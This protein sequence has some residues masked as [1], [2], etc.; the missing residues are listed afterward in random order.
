LAIIF[1]PI[2]R[3]VNAQR[4]IVMP[5]GKTRTSFTT[6]D[7]GEALAPPPSPSFSSP[8]LR[9][10]SLERTSGSLIFVS[11]CYREHCH[12]STS[13]RVSTLINT[14][15]NL[16]FF[17]SVWCRRGNRSLDVIEKK[18]RPSLAANFVRFYRPCGI[19]KPRR[20]IS[21]PSTW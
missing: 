4:C 15:S 2:C 11:P 6:H 20:T 12:S 19:Q 1:V 16:P 8:I 3:K 13:T 9:A 18:T 5:I 7:I 21:D 17:P 14:H 10:M